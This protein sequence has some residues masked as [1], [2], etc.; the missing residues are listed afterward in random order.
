[1]TAEGQFVC[2]GF[3]VGEHDR[4]RDAFATKLIAD[5]WRGLTLPVDKGISWMS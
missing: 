3:Q 1:V 4:V 2:I 5:Q